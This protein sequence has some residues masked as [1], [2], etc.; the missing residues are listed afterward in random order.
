MTGE[1]A[2]S[3]LCG[4]SPKVK[5]AISIPLA[6][7]VYASVAAYPEA[8]SSPVS[9]VRT[10]SKPIEIPDDDEFENEEPEEAENE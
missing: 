2:F 6:S 7:E 4:T 10:L 3:R 5:D 8:V 9:Y 1:I